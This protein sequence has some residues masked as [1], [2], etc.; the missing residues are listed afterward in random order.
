[1]HNGESTVPRPRRSARTGPRS[2]DRRCATNMR[3]RDRPA[4][5]GATLPRV[6]ISDWP[7]NDRKSKSSD[8]WLR[9]NR[10]HNVSPEACRGDGGQPLALTPSALSRPPAF[11]MTAMALVESA[12]PR[13]RGPLRHGAARESSA[14]RRSRGGSA[15]TSRAPQPSPGQARWPCD[16]SPIL[17]LTRPRAPV[18]QASPASFAARRGP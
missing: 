5:P 16:R 3:P 1:M 14:R 10:L 11:S 12:R 7:S 8:V 9:W 6:Q 2:L 15:V 4:S 17:P 18:R 13:H